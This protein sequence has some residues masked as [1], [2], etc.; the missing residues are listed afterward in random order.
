MSAAPPAGAAA[1]PG[2]FVTAWNA[3]KNTPGYNST[4]KN[5]ENMT[6]KSKAWNEYKKFLNAKS[7]APPPPAGGVDPKV[8]AAAALVTAKAVIN[9]TTKAEAEAAA[10]AASAAAETVKG[11]AL[12][13]E[14]KA[15]AERIT[16]IIA[17][18]KLTGGRRRKATKKSKKS[19]K[20]TRKTK[21]SK[22]SRKS[23]G[24]K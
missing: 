10:K 16:K 19:K 14:L 9:P 7:A 11:D 12:E 3:V 1:E 13:G 24:R 23:K 4:Y 5:A 21:K 2:P 20:A 17:D 22:R 18:K 8:A 15:E 6:K